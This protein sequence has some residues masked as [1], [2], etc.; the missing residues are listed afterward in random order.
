VARVVTTVEEVTDATDDV[1]AALARLVPQLTTTAP[2][3][4]TEI[5]RDVTTSPATTL[6]VARDGAEIVG[7]LTLVIF[8][9]AS[10]RRAWIED[11]IVDERARGRGVGEALVAAAV[12]RARAAGV[13]TVDLTSRS[14]REGAN[15][16]YLRLGFAVRETNLY[17]LTLDG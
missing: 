12:A 14:T 9:I 3:V 11:V 5:V 10:G 13:R 2:P 7:T 1:V 16:L 17:R 8:A 6:L 15:R 4:S